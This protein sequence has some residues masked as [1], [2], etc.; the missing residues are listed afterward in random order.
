MLPLAVLAGLT[1]LGLY[2]SRNESAE[3]M[4]APKPQ[5]CFAG[6]GAAPYL[7]EDPSPTRLPERPE[8]PSGAGG[9]RVPGPRGEGLVAHFSDSQVG[10]RKQP[11]GILEKNGAPGVGGP[12]RE[13]PSFGTIEPT[14]AHKDID[15]SRY[16][17]SER[18]DGTLPFEPER[19]RG[20]D[21]DTMHAAAFRRSVD[22]L[23]SAANPK[24]VAE[25]R[26]TAP[27]L[28]STLRGEQ[29]KHHIRSNRNERCTDFT[30]APGNAAV[31]RGASTGEH[32]VHSSRCRD[33]AP[34]PL[35]IAS[36]ASGPIAVRKPTTRFADSTLVTPP[37]GI[38]GGERARDRD[39][40]LHMFEG[41]LCEPERGDMAAPPLG[42]A[43]STAMG[44]HGVPFEGASDVSRGTDDAFGNKK[45]VTAKNARIYGALQVVGPPKQTVYEPGDPL[46]TTL[47]ETA[48]HDQGDGWLRGP[49]ATTARDPD[50]VARMTGRQTL[51]DIQG[52]RG[53]DGRLDGTNVLQKP[54]AYDPNDVFDVTTRETTERNTHT[55]HIGTLEERGSSVA[56]PP[57]EQTQRALTH[58]SYFGDAARPVAD[59]YRVANPLVHGTNR[60][61]KPKTDYR[62]AASPRVPN[63]PSSEEVYTRVLGDARE[64]TLARRSPRG[65]R[66]SLPS[67]VDGVRRSRRA[68]IDPYLDAQPQRPAFQDQRRSQ[69]HL[70]PKACSDTR[71]GR[72]VFDSLPDPAVLSQL[73]SNPYALKSS[74]HVQVR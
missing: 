36:Q 34:V 26:V 59:G 1:G 56:Q 25:G 5:K 55:G 30:Y 65:M 22:E 40:D 10:F 70:D 3:T 38:A 11:P 54:P 72:R 69:L 14:P 23:R 29:G 42:N 51:D 37:G 74:G 8:A 44:T 33:G 53:D 17:V 57:L 50:A 64:R 63:M 61:V 32:F 21:S 18:R 39:M 19:P 73:A 7:P 6:G 4:E 28:K 2:I 47:K 49:L 35:G 45:A 62:G 60:A 13:L 71:G 48:I 41:A 20:E 24:L 16:T 27:P 9:L 67:G 31:K 46:R 15:R 66:E 43:H 68:R 12:K 58:E 52:A